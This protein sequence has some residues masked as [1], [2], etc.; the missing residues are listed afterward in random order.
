VEERLFELTPEVAPDVCVH[1]A[2][3]RQTAGAD[4]DLIEIGIRS[5]RDGGVGVAVTLTLEELTRLR[6]ALTAIIEAQLP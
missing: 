2:D 5:H 6:D 3:D 1:V 4:E